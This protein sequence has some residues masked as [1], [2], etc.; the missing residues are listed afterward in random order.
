MEA[1]QGPVSASRVHTAAGGEK[2]VKAPDHWGERSCTQVYVEKST[3]EHF[4][5]SIVCSTG[6]STRKPDFCVK[7]ELSTV[8]EKKVAVTL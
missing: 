3:N 7:T 6:C 1:R 5:L 8:L 4:H 2:T